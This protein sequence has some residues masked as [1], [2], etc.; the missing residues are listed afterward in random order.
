[1][2]WFRKLVA[3]HGVQGLK[4]KI[5]KRCFKVTSRVF[6]FFNRELM[7][8]DPLEKLDEIG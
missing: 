1:M 4:T 6:S 5:A 2:H 8:R 3:V 7:N